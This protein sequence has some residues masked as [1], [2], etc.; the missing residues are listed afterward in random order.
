MTATK[1]ALKPKH[2]PRF[3]LALRHERDFWNVLVMHTMRC[4]PCLAVQR[5]SGQHGFA[6]DTGRAMRDEWLNAARRRYELSPDFT[7][8]EHKPLAEVKQHKK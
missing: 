6:C 1:S 3:T 7:T 2:S 5:E 4:P 8:C